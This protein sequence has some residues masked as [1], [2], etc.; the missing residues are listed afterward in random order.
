MSV[1][2]RNTALRVLLAVQ[3][4]PSGAAM[5]LQRQFEGE[6]ELS[7]QQ[8]AFVKRL[9][10]G[11]LGEQLRLDAV[12][13]RYSTKPVGKLRPAIR[14]ILRM[15]VYQILYMDAVPD[16]AAC[17]EQVALARRYGFSALSGFVNA[18]LR[19]VCREKEALLAELGEASAALRF[20]MPEWILSL[21]ERQYG[22]QQAE[23]T[24][25]A[26]QEVRPVTLRLRGREAVEREALVQS[27]RDAG[28]V[29]LPAPWLPYAVT[30]RKTS[31]IRL[32]L[33]YAEG[34]FVVQ[35]VASM[36]ATEAAG[37]RGGEC[38]YD[39]CA[40]PGGKS[41]HC[42]DRLLALPGRESGQGRVFAFDRYP[43]KL[44]RLRDNLR[45][46]RLEEMVASSVR[47][48]REAVPEEERGRADVILCDVPCSGLGV[49]G[50]KRDIRYRL[51]EEDLQEL[52]ALQRQIAAA[53]VLY[54]RPGT[55]FL[56]ST[57]TINRMENEEN[58]DYLEKAL[59]LVPDPLAPH[60]PEG[61]PGICGHMLQLLPQL[62]GTDGFFIARFR[63][64]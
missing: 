2:E 48:A 26:M 3:K 23:E 34:G 41:M 55:V 17:N 40:A 1:N 60:L 53:A 14:W 49:M 7:A 61:I 24:A 11:C 13:G 9:T 35:D 21:W 58:A 27:L 28:A 6:P 64:P 22:R 52:A 16:A 47:D 4:E 8:R 36:L 63:L 19:R 32:L 31:D 54:G 57:C 5:L 43:G 46:L 37:L 62:H 42:A 20:S 56:Y 12:I 18:I 15:G 38:V 59:G 33:G 25:A 30:V 29:V 50:R 10:Q 44:R 51:R 45:R 39:V